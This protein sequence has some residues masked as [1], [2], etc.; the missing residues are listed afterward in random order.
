MG[1]AVVRV[2]TKSSDREKAGE[3]MKGLECQEEEL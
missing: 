1:A 2:R 3:L